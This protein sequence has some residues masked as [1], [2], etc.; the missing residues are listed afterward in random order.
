LAPQPMPPQGLMQHFQ[1]GD[2]G[3]NSSGPTLVCALIFCFLALIRSWFGPVLRW[4]NN[5][6]VEE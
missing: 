2:D 1:S 6:Y 5:S 3:G 4:K